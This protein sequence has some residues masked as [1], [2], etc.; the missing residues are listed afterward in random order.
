MSAATC[1]Q[2]RSHVHEMLQS[3]WTSTTQRCL[4][5]SV[6]VCCP[7]LLFP[8]LCKQIRCPWLSWNSSDQAWALSSQQGWIWTRHQIC[9]YCATSASV[10]SPADEAL[11]KKQQIKKT[12]SDSQT[13]STSFWIS[14]VMGN[15]SVLHLVWVK[16]D[17]F[18]CHFLTVRGRRSHWRSA[19]DAAGM[20]ANI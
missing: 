18:L 5:A 20:K 16:P 13:H 15:F 2:H 10:S 7:G 8:V 17:R 3:F 1:S 6:S 11:K 9:I 4:H 14:T 12:G 19:G